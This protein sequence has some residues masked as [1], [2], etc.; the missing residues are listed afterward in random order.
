MKMWL[1]TRAGMLGALAFFVVIYVFDRAPNLNPTFPEGAL[2]WCVVLSLFTGAWVLFDIGSRTGGLFGGG[3]GQII[4]NFKGFALRMLPKWARYSMV[5]VWGLF[6]TTI[7]YSTVFFHW[8]TCRDQL[9]QPLVQTFSSN[10]QAVDL[11]KLPIVDGE[12][13]SK[14]ADKKLG[15][16]PALGSQVRL[17]QPTI[18]MV[19]GQLLW[20]V[21]LH[22]SGFFKW[23]ANLQGSAGYITVSATNINEVQYI[24]TYKIKYQ[25]DGFLLHNL[26]RWTRFSAAPFSGITDF[27]LEIDD[28]G[29]PHWIITTYRNLRGFSLPEAT[30]VI[31]MNAETGRSFRYSVEDAPSWVDRVQPESLIISQINNQGEYVH[32]FLNFSDKDKYRASEGHAIVYNFGRCYLFT[33]LTSVGS[34]E[35]SI[36]FIMVD[37]VTKQP[38]LYQMN[39]ATEYAAQSS[40]RGKVQHLGYDASFPLII[41]AESTPTYFMTLK[42]REGLIKQYAL[43]SVTNYSVVGV[44]DTVTQTY[45]SYQEALRQGGYQSGSLIP[46]GGDLAVYKGR[47]KR[48]GSRVDAGRT[49]YHIILS[50]YPQLV[51]TAEDSLSAKLPLTRDADYVSISCRASQGQTTLEAEAFDNIDLST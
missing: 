36:G 40:A 10:I 37:M 14:L 35:S 1:K 23:I 44:G 50:E 48:I 4:F 30:G 47:V 46:S 13:A 17:G 29:V 39:G 41:N 2:F 18:Q 31:V 38:L 42:D 49:V 21:P 25:P 26:K 20:V 7:V 15:E 16:R 8:R 3:S 33:G 27:A 24:D 51:F 34:D 19:D 11:S 28:S 6:L 9:G 43:V 45:R 12:L 22:H 5:L 32:G